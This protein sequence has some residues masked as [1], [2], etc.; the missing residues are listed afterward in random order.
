MH[1]SITCL[2]SVRVQL[3]TH[4]DT[5]FQITFGKYFD[6]FEPIWK[7][8]NNVDYFGYQSGHV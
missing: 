8:L 7:L 2:G 4:H 1:T 6:I 5:D 3:K